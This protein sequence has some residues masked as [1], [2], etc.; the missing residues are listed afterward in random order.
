MRKFSPFIFV[1]VWLASFQGFILLVLKWLT[2]L[3]L[4]RSSLVVLV[5]SGLRVP[6]FLFSVN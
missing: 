4:S 2:H 6:R 3:N 1:V 5:P